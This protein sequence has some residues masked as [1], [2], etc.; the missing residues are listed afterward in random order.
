MTLSYIMA[1]KSKIDRLVHI[2]NQEGA[3]QLFEQ[4][5]REC[6][7]RDMVY[8]YFSGVLLGELRLAVKELES[9]HAQLV[10]ATAQTEAM[11]WAVELFTDNKQA[12]SPNDDNISLVIYE[13]AEMIKNAMLHGVSNDRLIKHFSK[14]RIV[15]GCPIT[16][17]EFAD[18]RLAIVEAI[19]VCN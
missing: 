17:E 15:Y 16:E 11:D 13:A 2:C 12:E 19:P 5:K 7:R 1:G 9:Y 8:P 18:K 10:D 4:A 6:D 14:N 3:D